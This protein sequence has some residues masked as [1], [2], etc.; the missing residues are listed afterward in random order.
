MAFSPS[1]KYL[2]KCHKTTML[3][4]CAFPKSTAQMQQKHPQMQ[5]QIVFGSQITK[6]HTQ[7]WGFTHIFMRTEITIPD[8]LQQ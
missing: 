4:L 6:K 8:P 7:K 3:Q 1:I 5:H 2:D